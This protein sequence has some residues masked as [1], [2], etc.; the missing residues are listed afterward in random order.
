MSLAE[1]LGE[2]RRRAVRAAIA[3]A[4]G[5]VAGWF[6]ADV[7]LALLRDPIAVAAL[8]QDRPVALNFTSV[9]AAFDLR[10][11]IAVVAGIVIASPVWLYQLFAFFMPALNKREH[12]YTL[13]FTFAALPLFLAGCAA[14]IWVVPHIVA[15]LTAFAP[16]DSLT[17]L[18]A[19]SYFDFVLRLVLITGVAF[20]L[21]LV[22]VLLNFAGVV[23]GVAIL[24][25]WR[26]AVLSI[27]LFTA[28]ATPAADVMAML[29]LAIPMVLLY[30]GACGVALLSDRRRS[31]ALSATIDLPAVEV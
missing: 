31:R 9:S 24:K 29:L 10:V 22:L 4:A 5:M 2:L 13:G 30:V 19:R 26:W 1:H 6:L 27:C 28:I 16:A 21:P 12:R 15:L 3:L 8:Q 18:D 7:V 11:Q 25:A 17:Y 20:V 23:S 14:G